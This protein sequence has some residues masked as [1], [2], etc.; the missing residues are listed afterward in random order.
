MIFVTTGSQKF[1][2]NRLLQKID[3]LIEAGD[4]KEEVFAQIGESDYQPKHYEYCR[5]LD[6]ESFA[7][8]LRECRMV[9][10]HGGTGVIIGAVKQGKKVIA[11]PRLARYGEHVDD[12]QV[13]LLREFDGMNLIC[14]CYDCEQLGG[15][16][17]ETQQREFA[18]Y[19]SNT[20]RILTDMEQFLNAEEGERHD[21]KR[22]AKH[23]K[24]T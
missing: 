11:V 1:Q 4:I 17:R 3:L 12:H 16:I 20:R 15:C 19:H 13:Q 14:A 7:G 8:K 10:T 21:R 23:T 9:I 18:E 6:R 24:I 5:F 2:F 22:H